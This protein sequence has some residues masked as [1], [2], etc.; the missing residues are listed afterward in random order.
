VAYMPR[1][2]QQAHGSD[3]EQAADKRAGEQDALSLDASLD[4]SED[5]VTLA[6]LLADTGVH[7][8]GRP[9]RRRTAPRSHRHGRV[10]ER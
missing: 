1:Y 9:R 4:D 5:G 2:P 10:L 3:R 6:D 8:A 7:P